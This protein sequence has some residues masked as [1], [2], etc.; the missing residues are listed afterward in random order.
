MND[1]LEFATQ[2]EA[3]TAADRIHLK[4]IEVDADYARS[5]SLGHTTAWAIPYQ[6]RDAN[7][8]VI[9]TLWYVNIKDRGRKAAEPEDLPKLKPIIKPE[10]VI[11]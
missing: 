1:R 2:E 6:D 5:V 8:N 3:Q 11:K 9:G 10:V 7:G 4:M